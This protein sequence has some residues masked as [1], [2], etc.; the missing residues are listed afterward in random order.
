MY[1]AVGGIDKEVKA[2]KKQGWKLADSQKH[3][4]SQC[5]KW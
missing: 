2:V 3:T 4:H 5:I 1:V